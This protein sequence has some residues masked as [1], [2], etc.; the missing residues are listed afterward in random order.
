MAALADDVDALAERTGFSGVVQVET[1]GR[2]ELAKAYGMAD[3]AHQIAN[4]VETQFAIASGSK[5]LTALAVVAL[6]DD[7]VLGLATT[8]R[9]VLGTDSSPAT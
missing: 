5:A 1:G 2:A 6:I 9:S 8:A 4:A 7:G 3:R